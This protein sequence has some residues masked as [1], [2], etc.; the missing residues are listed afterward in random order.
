[1][2]PLHC[3]NSLPLT[4]PVNVALP[5][6]SLPLHY[7]KTLPL[8]SPVNVALP[9]NSLPLHYNK[10]LPGPGIPCEC[11]STSSRPLHR[12][13]KRMIITYLKTGEEENKVYPL[14][15]PCPKGA[16]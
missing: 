9:T 5:T 7:N 12:L 8:A 1:M 3:N 10:T 2:L 15:L 4:S 6:N 16:C 14:M 13:D 11:C